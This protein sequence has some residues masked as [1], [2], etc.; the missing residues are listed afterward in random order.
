MPVI[1][2]FEVAI[3]VDDEDL[4]QYPLPVPKFSLPKRQ[5]QHETE[6][7]GL[8][9]VNGTAP[10]KP[11]VREGMTRNSPTKQSNKAKAPGK[12][13]KT[14]AQLAAQAQRAEKQKAKRLR[15]QAAQKERQSTCL[16][17]ATAGKNFEIRVKGNNDFDT[18]VPVEGL[19]V[20]VSIDGKEVDS[21]FMDR[22][23]METY[24][25]GRARYLEGKL[26]VEPF[27]FAKIKIGG[28]FNPFM[29]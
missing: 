25:A 26:F 13:K 6:V 5:P 20:V 16:V 15:A 19:E 29:T 3:V 1:K 12:V 8:T 24:S 23:C 27:K 22:D 17:E 10:N 14:S 11:P 7:R 21:S 18:E 28:C 4:P 9:Q 2:G